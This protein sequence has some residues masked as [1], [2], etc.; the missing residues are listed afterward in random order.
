MEI[1]TFIE[2]LKKLNVGFYTGV[3]DSQLKSLCD[4]L[5]ATY[6]ISSTHLIAV[7]EGNALGLASGYHIATGKIPCVYLQNSGLGN[8][9]NPL[10]SLTHPLVYGIPT[11]FVIGWRGQP[12]VHDEPQ[13]AFMGAITEQIMIDLQI[14]PIYLTKT[15]TIDQ[16]NEALRDAKERLSEGKSIA[17]LVSKEALT[18]SIKQSYVNDCT[19]LRESLIQE[20]LSVTDQDIIVATTG[21]TS[22]EVFEVRQQRH[23]SH[24]HDFLTVGSMGHTSSIALGIAL[25]QPNRKVWCIDGDG[26]VLMHMGS[27]ALIGDRQPENLRHIVINNGAHES[28]GGQPTSNTHLH[29]SKIAQDCGYRTVFL[30]TSMAEF[31]QALTQAKSGIGPIL[32]EMRSAI[33]SRD[34]LGRPTSTPSENKI[35]FMDNL[36]TNP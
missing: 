6:G 30:A 31:K 18:S 5:I 28:V 15:T 2:T 32:I 16:L 24:D 22:R 12:G 25:Y 29:I 7:N 9:I 36:K 1:T 8:L 11:V 20:I 14:A 34:D 21:K 4:Y 35:H 23:E 19:I 33:G 27:M 13:H 17:F 10:T 26:A 3:P